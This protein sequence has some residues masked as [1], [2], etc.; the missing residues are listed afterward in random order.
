MRGVKRTARAE[1]QRPVSLVDVA[2]VDGIAFAA[3]ARSPGFIR[4]PEGNH[5]ALIA[6]LAQ[7]HAL[8]L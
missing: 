3:I 8:R 2:G 5:S 6:K 4:A 1:I 7:S